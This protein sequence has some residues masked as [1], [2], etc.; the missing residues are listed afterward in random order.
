MATVVCARSVTRRAPWSIWSRIWRVDGKPIE[1]REVLKERYR[2]EG[3]FF[4]YGDPSRPWGHAARRAQPSK[5]FNPGPSPH[6]TSKN[7]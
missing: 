6:K 7:P 4:L 3:C 1:C 5:T 2:I